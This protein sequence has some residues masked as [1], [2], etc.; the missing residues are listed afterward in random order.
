MRVPYRNLFV[1]ALCGTLSY[2]AA[3]VV[4]DPS[5]ARFESQVDVVLV[6]VVVRDRHGSPVG[7]LT[8][9][10]FRLFD[11]GKRR[12][13]TSFVAVGPATEASV[14]T[15]DGSKST[16]HLTGTNLTAPHGEVRRR[17]IYLFDDLNT[18]FADMAQLREAAVRH[19]RH[20]LPAGDEVAIYSFS[21]RLLSG[22]SNDP[23]KLAVIAGKLRWRPQVGHG[24]MN[25]PDVSYYIADLVMTKG[26]S[27]AL[28]ALTNH[29]MACAHMPLEPAKL[30]AESAATRELKIGAEDT[31]VALGT[32]RRAIRQLSSMP[33]QR[34]VVLASPGLFLQTPAGARSLEGVLDL[35]AK[36]NVIVNGL[37]PR[38]VIVAEGRAERGRIVRRGR[39]PPS[40]NSPSDKW[41]AYRRES[42]RAGEDVMADLAD[43]TGGTYFRENNDLNLGFVKTATTA[44]ISYVLGFSPVSLKMDGTFHPLKVLLQNERG[45][46]VEARRGYYAI[47]NESRDSHA[48]D[49]I[50]DEVFARNTANDIP[51]VVQTGYSKQNGS[52]DATVLIVAK[53]ELTALHFRKLGGRNN[54]S[55]RAVAVL[56]D[57]EGG[58]VAGSEKTARLNVRDE[59]LKQADPNVTLRWEFNVKT[60]KYL[61]RLVMREA[62]GKAMTTLSRPLNIQN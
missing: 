27:E 56:F 38:G 14:Q 34:V 4:E 13:I 50:D 29:T 46:K 44:Q 31:Q 59:T 30:L 33:G 60:G 47:K 41:K 12:V 19:F 9:D 48:T 15:A 11:K 57:E 18:R 26:S 5:S 16:G 1:I 10:D 58:Y 52:D 49:E 23:E 22:F 28:A 32:L 45:D 51:L 2:L 36:S 55:F 35:A 54:D 39:R 61:I 25:C 53:V 42:A 24:G 8:K 17:L 6:P 3:Q 7:N 43:G 21:G 37:S 62:D 40:Q 20:P